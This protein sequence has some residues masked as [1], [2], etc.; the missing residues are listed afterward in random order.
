[1]A[2]APK[3]LH[4]RMAILGYYF[5]LALLVGLISMLLGSYYV[6]RMHFRSSRASQ[7]DMPNVLIT[8]ELLAKNQGMADELYL[9]IVGHVFNVTAG[10]RFYGGN[11]GYAFF[12][13]RDAT[14][15][16]ATGN[17]EDQDLVE[18]FRGLSKE[19]CKAIESW[20]AFYI[21]HESYHLIGYLEGSMYFHSNGTE[22]SAMSEF[23][24]CAAPSPAQ[25]NHAAVVD[26]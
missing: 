7:Y 9:S 25:L 3:D 12:A 10:R 15:A 14:R 4:I 23:R 21:A 18:E 11:T 24:E 20:L 2:V 5:A 19:Q 17:F 8:R 13:G 1:V 22:T 26:Q 6:Y 16:F